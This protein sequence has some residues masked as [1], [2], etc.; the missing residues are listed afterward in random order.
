MGQT[1]SRRTTH[2]Q[3]LCELT[4]IPTAAGCEQR[5]VRWIEQ[6]VG[7]RP[8]LSM[9]AD[10]AGNLTIRCVN[11]PESDSPIYI[12]AHLDHPAFVID[13]VMDSKTIRASFR[14]GVMTPYFAGAEVVAITADDQ[15]FNGRVRT[16]EPADPPARVF[17]QCVIDLEDD[18]S[19]LRPGDFVRW[20]LPA[21]E[22]RDGCLHAPA[23]D[24]LAAAVAAL[25]AL[26]ELR[27]THDTDVRVLFTVAEEVGFIGAIAACKL[28]TMPAGSRVIALENSRAMDGAKIGGGPIV[29]VGDRLS[30]FSNTLTSAICDAAN[31]LAGVG[32]RPVGTSDPAA[33]PT[34]KWQRRLMPGGACEATAFQAWGYDATCVCLGLGNYH[35][36]GDLDRVQ[37]AMQ[38]D[39]KDIEAPIAPESISVD[40][41]HGLIELLVAC[42]RS[43]DGAQ[44]VTE[45][46]EKLYDERAFV[47]GASMTKQEKQ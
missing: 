39:E 41:F 46:L 24:D 11:A 4:S 12:T 30:V 3:W 22:I 28:G 38:N 37:G 31:R 19:G 13:D 5:V 9:T 10:A 29:R 34:F 26:D 15:R 45:R 7:E 25:A 36:M 32:D 40:D 1:D 27:E 6:W 21:S 44:P 35:N 42:G 20:R 14:G 17:A 23:C 16:H 33:K 43:L 2:E 47:L 18:A 8:N